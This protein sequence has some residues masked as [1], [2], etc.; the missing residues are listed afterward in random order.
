MA[1]EPGVVRWA[2]VRWEAGAGLRLERLALCHSR[3]I[4]LAAFEESST[5]V[6]YSSRCC[7]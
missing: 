5:A 3:R 2:G 7:R 1:Q 6:L 4:R